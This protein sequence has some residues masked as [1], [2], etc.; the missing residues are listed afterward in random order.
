MKQKHLI[1]LSVVIVILAMGG[2]GYD[3]FCVLTH[4]PKPAANSN[5][6]IPSMTLSDKYTI[7]EI[8]RLEAG[9]PGYA[10]PSTLEPVKEAKEGEAAPRPESHSATLALATTP[11]SF[12]VVDGS[13]YS[14]G[15]TLPDGSVIE[16]IESRLVLINSGGVRGWLTVPLM[17]PP[18]PEKQKETQG[19]GV[20]GTAAGGA[21]T[22]AEGSAGA[23]TDPV[24]KPQEGASQQQEEKKSG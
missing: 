22:S 13:L 20:A 12:C 24:I 6:I 7:S 16:R 2:A 10:Q 23:G 9:L 18:Q 3:A 4:K 19:D 21:A 15:S 8:E 17:A 14:T 11:Q 5:D 1:L